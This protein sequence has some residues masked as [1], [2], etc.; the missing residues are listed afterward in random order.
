M[1]FALIG[2]MVLAMSLTAFAG[3]NPNVR[4]F[5]TMDPAGYVHTAMPASGD[6]VNTYLC[7]D[8]FGDPGV[9][10]DGGLTGISLVLD[11]TCG[12][13][14]AGSAD[15][16]IFHPSAQTVVG[17]PDDL[18]NGWVIAAPECVVPGPSDIICVAMVPWYYLD[19]A[20]DILILP[21]PADGKATVDCNNDLDVFCVFS[22]GAL[23]QEVQTAGDADCDC[24][25][26]PVD[27]TT[28][29]AI[30]SLYR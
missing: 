9:E 5:V 23:G 22:H 2:L 24:L 11:Y 13:F 15:V 6:I 3:E 1:K 19:P 4:A 29:G 20:G 27:D 26:V 18:A 30:K 17:G 7:F 21:S 25:A 28:W 16:T 14:T 8:C 10:G 12:G